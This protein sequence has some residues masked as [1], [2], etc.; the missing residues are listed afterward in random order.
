MAAQKAG[1]HRK[2][3]ARARE[4]K[5]ERGERGTRHIRERE[6]ERESRRAERRAEERAGRPAWCGGGGPPSAQPSGRATIHD[7]EMGLG[8]VRNKE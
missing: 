7:P 3:R 6:G 2:G 5:G 4:R 8:E 1:G